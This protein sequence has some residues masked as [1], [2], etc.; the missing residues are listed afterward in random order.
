[1]AEGSKQL[2]CLLWDSYK[3][4]REHSA[5][6]PPPASCGGGGDGDGIPAECMVTDS[7]VGFPIFLAEMLKDN[8]FIP[9]DLEGSISSM[10][11]I[12]D[13]CNSGTRGM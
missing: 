13:L 12:Q 9:L 5:P 3:G 4:V 1:M 10:L 8:L 7:R 2:P 6:C 11:G